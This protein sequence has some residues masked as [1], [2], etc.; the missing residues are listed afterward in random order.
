[1]NITKLIILL[2]YNLAIALF[3][4]YQKELKI[5]VHTKKPAHR[6]L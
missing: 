1:M 6:C 4:I 5:C 2:P 3:D